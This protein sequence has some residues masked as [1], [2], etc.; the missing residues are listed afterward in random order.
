MSDDVP[1]PQQVKRWPDATRWGLC[2]AVA[3][4]VHVG[5]AAALLAHWHDDSDLTAGAPVVMIDLAPAAV[6][7]NA[8]PADTPAP[9]ESKAQPEPDPTPEKPTEQTSVEPEPRPQKPPEE[10]PEIKPEPEKSE[11]AMLPPRRPVE[12][13]VE[14]KPKPKHKQASLASA[15]TAAEQKAERAAAP[16]AGAGSH[17]PNAVPNWKS[18]LVARLERAKRYPPEAQSRGDHGVVRIAFSIDRSG[19]VHNARIVGSS[20]SSL[21]DQATLSLLSRAAPLPPPPAEMGAQVAI[22]VPIRYNIR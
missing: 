17:N 21:L 16:S 3:L 6:S 10:K 11:L 4:F 8:T 12:K 1:P 9:V 2:F 22:V 5:G 7:P 20:G 18:E 15:P 19:G 14:K 13:P